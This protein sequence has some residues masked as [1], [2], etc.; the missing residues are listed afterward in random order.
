MQN[1][2]NSIVN[3]KNIALAGISEDTK[4]FGNT[5]YKELTSK[6]Y[7]IF[8]I[9]PAKA[10]INGIKCYPN[11]HEIKDKIEALLICVKPDKALDLIKQAKE[12]NISNI[13]LQNGA[14]SPEVIKL[15]KELNLNI[16]ANRC[17]LMY[18]PPVKS[19]HKFHRTINKIF[20]KL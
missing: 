15:A 6:G 8:P 16:V 9:H 3:S 13:W 19:V 17:I 4:K 5:L 12:A 7:N 2:I 14:G 10:E 20:G 1:I 11:L 18:A